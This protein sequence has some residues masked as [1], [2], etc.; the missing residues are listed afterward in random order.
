MNEGSIGGL[1]A[2][3]TVAVAAC[4]Y[5]A[6]KRYHHNKE[7]SVN[8]KNQNILDHKQEIV[9]SEAEQ[10]AKLTAALIAEQQRAAVLINEHNE[11][12][13]TAVAISTE[14]ELVSYQADNSTRTWPL[15]SSHS[16]ATTNFYATC[17]T[18]DQKPIPKKSHLTSVQQKKLQERE[19]QQLESEN[20]ET[21]TVLRQAVV[22]IEK[23]VDVVLAEQAQW[24]TS[25]SQTNNSP[26]NTFH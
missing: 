15:P 16:V 12:Q 22:Q 19:I 7:T 9:L 5:V 24:Y 13:K 20:A 2:F 4:C 8:K 1:V 3:A 11:L 23:D 6:V 14:D 17:T 25:V 26:K 21:V 10:L 18:S